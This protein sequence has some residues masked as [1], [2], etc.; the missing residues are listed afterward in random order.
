MFLDMFPKDNEKGRAKARYCIS[1]EEW[2]IIEKFRITPNKRKFIE[3]QKKLDKEG[4]LV[5]TVEKLQSE[6][7]DIPDNFEIIKISWKNRHFSYGQY[8]PKRH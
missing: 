1:P 3:T 8:S 6:P 5:S 2:R 4:E 7:I